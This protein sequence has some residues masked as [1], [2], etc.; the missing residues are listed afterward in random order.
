ME[1]LNLDTTHPATKQL[2]ASAFPEPADVYLCDKCG[3]DVTVHL[4]RGRAHVRQ[5]LG[6]VRYFCRCGQDYLS[7]ATEWDYLSDWEK[8]Q[9]LADI[10]LMCILFTALAGFVVFA[11]FALVRRSAVMI[12]LSVVGVPFA[13]AFLRLF[14]ITSA[15]PFEIAA[16]RWRTRGSRKQ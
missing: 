15:V 9:W 3:S 4:Q 13:A 10:P 7:G 12:L 11:Y 16:S 2:C 1:A 6:P 8:R 14:I 5:P